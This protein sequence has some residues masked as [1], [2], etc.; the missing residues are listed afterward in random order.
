M[1]S[2]KESIQKF[3]DF[4][5]DG[6]QLKTNDELIKVISEFGNGETEFHTIDI[7]RLIAESEE[8]KELIDYFNRFKTMHELPNDNTS[9]FNMGYVK[10]MCDA[11][12]M[13]KEI[14]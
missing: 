5:V 9:Q 3:Q 8:S 13:L 11:I 14:Y 2:V 12:N 4:E 10:A 1:R 7:Y 6:H